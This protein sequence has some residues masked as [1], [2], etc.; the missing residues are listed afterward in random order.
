MV[1]YE[2]EKWDVFRLYDDEDSRKWHRI[3][4]P[5]GTNRTDIIPLGAITDGYEYKS[6]AMVI[7]SN[8][9]ERTAYLHGKLVASIKR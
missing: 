1:R 4:I 7:F 5:E 2:F 8:E 3:A 9:N 6:N